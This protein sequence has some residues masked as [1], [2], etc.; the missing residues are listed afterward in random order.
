MES[1]ELIIFGQVHIAGK[2]V[3]NSMSFKKSDEKLDSNR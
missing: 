2:M 3:K 1:D